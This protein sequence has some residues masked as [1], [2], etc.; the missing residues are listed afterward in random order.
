MPRKRNTAICARLTV[1]SGQYRGGFVPQ[2]AVIPPRTS[3]SIHEPEGVS[4]PA[5]RRTRRRSPRSPPRFPHSPRRR[6]THWPPPGCPPSA[7]ASDSSCCWPGPT[8]SRRP[9]CRSRRDRSPACASSKPVPSGRTWIDF[10]VLP[11]GSL[12]VPEHDRRLVRRP[13]TGTVVIPLLL[14]CPGLPGA[15][16]LWFVFTAKSAALSAFP[17]KATHPLAAPGCPP[18]APASDSS[19]CWPGPTRSR[20][21]RCRSRRDRSPAW[22][23]W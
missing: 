22:P 3:A 16:G 21:P 6:P 17:P 20:R 9:R 10:T 14:N 1:W 13:P 15:L 4:S 2:P 11:S 7:L 5:H 12:A 8:R 19:C 23:C 18:S